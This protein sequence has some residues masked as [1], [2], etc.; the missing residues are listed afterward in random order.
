MTDVIENKNVDLVE[1]INDKIVVSSKQVAENF[2]KL[3]KDVLENIE[4]YIT[5]ENS[6]LT[7]WFFK[8]TYTAG[9]GK[10]Y[11]MYLM[12]RDGFSLLV[13]GFTGKKAL[14]W[15][16][17]YIDAFNK[18]EAK[19]KLI[20]QQEIGR[21]I[22]RIKGKEIRRTL[23]DAIKENVPD[24]PYKKFMYKNFTDLVYKSV[25]GMTA[26]QIRTARGLKKNANVRDFLSEK[27]LKKVRA[28]ECIVKGYL[29]IGNTYVEI[30]DALAGKVIAN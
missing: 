27:E 10:R 8:T 6:A 5:A 21:L 22:E 3:H 23:T 15:K 29:D 19:L 1:I 14:E 25:F 12:N 18:M 24:S 26:R 9:T 28:A 2:G 30:N 17:K 11:P 7:N 4:K 16:I 20:E 13:M